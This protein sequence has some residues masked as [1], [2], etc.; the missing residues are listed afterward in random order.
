MFEVVICTVST[1][2]VEKKCFATR[3]EAD[4]FVGRRREGWEK[5]NRS[6]RNYRVEVREVVKPAVEPA[7]LPEA[8]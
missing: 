5:S 7:R 8:A 6:P 4:R 2:R 3:E 1:G